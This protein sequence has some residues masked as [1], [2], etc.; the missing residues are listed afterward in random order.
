MRRIAI[1]V[2][3]AACGE[4][5]SGPRVDAGPCEDPFLNVPWPS[6]ADPQVC[7][8][9]P[10]Q[11]AERTQCGEVK[12][13]CDSTGVVT[14]NLACLTGTPPVLPPDPA[15]VTLEGFAD[16]FSNGPSADGVRVQ[17][18]RA[19]D[20]TPAITDLSQVTP[21][22]TTDLVLDATT[23]MTARACPQENNDPEEL[24]GDCVLPD[25]DCVGCDV[26][27]DAPDFCYKTQCHPM[28][29]W[30]VYYSIPN[31]PTNTFLVIRT[32]GL[33]G[34][35]VNPDHVTWA[36]LVQY[37]VF[38]STADPACVL[39]PYKGDENCLDQSGATP[40]YRLNANL[41]SRSDYETIPITAGL[42]GG[43][44]PGHGAVAGEVHDCDDIRVG[45][46]QIGFDP[47]PLRPI[48]F[49][50][51]PVMTLPEIGGA[52]RGTDRLGLFA[53]LD[54]PPGDVTVVALGDVGG[55][56]TELGRFTARV[57]PNTVTTVGINGGKPVQPQ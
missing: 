13:D 15:T 31:V 35:A 39:D 23:V 17:V 36:P 10:S 47:I 56:L 44:T 22:A 1:L 4:S 14:P 55:T 38:L 46:A 9:P 12:E 52:V 24:R 26:A 19:A 42:S 27:V 28:Q 29:R 7:S 20:I 30:E 40:V 8:R 2:V 21:I 25:N 16:V 32:I 34:A 51:N 43:V 49:N 11:A 33:D 54:L 45:F 18:F 57:F 50:G 3:L 37:N 48:Y 5:N 41:L 6:A 53:G